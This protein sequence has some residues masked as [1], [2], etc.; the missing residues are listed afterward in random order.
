M[1]NLGS[2]EQIERLAVAIAEDLY[3]D[4]AKWHLYVDD[5][6]DEKLHI[7]LAEQL[8]PLVAEARITKDAVNQILAGIKITIGGGKQEIP[9]SQFI[10][11]SV[12]SMLMDVL[13]AHKI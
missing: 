7:L 11:A 6:K 2:S 13:T 1:S 8:F 4:V 10:P 12:E 3:L 9:M 5:I